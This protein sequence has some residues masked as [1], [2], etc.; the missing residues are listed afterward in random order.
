[1]GGTIEY[2]SNPSSNPSVIPNQDTASLYLLPSKPPLKHTNSFYVNRTGLLIADGG[3]KHWSFYLYPGSQIV[4]TA[5]A[6]DSFNSY[7]LNLIKGSSNY[8]SWSEDPLDSSYINS[9]ILI[10]KCSPL[11][12]EPF[13]KKLVFE[14]HE[15]DTY[16]IILQ[17]TLLSSHTYYRVA[18]RES[19]WICSQWYTK[20][21]RSPWLYVLHH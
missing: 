16:Y 9:S 20:L 13:T 6:E 2:D 17:N 10:I 15:E 5:C 11:S 7:Y 1:M 14:V 19:N 8:K 21:H 18:V 4:A 12:G 3:W